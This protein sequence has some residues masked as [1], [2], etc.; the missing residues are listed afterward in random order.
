MNREPLT[1][2]SA[3]EQD[4]DNTGTL[5]P[6][7]VEAARSG[8]HLPRGY[9]QRRVK[10]QSPEGQLQAWVEELVLEEPPDTRPESCGRE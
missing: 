1:H 5:Y 6:F 3:S 8:V 2:E 4:F 7:E 10:A 9:F